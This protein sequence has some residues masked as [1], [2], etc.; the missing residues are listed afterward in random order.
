M[1][2]SRHRVSCTHWNIHD[3]RA[4]FVATPWCYRNLSFCFCN[5]A[6]QFQAFL[7]TP[8]E[9]H[10]KRRAAVLL[11]LQP[12]LQPLHVAVFSLCTSLLHGVVLAALQTDAIGRNT[13]IATS[14]H[15]GCA[16]RAV[17]ADLSGKLRG[18]ALHPAGA[19]DATRRG[20]VGGGCD[21]RGSH[22]LHLGS[23]VARERYGLDKPTEAAPDQILTFTRRGGKALWLVVSGAPRITPR[24][25][26][27]GQ[28][29][30]RGTLQRHDGGGHAQRGGDIHGT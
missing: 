1:P 11:E 25:Q 28:Q 5:A 9:F 23:S 20:N 7:R 29:R 18:A 22:L 4:A 2:Q 8:F 24:K 19:D 13:V 30:R 17:A 3:C 14:L 26:R 21:G 16:Q 6:F 12:S 10:R 15:R 27:R